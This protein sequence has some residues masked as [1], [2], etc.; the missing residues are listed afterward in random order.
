MFAVAQNLAILFC[1]GMAFSVHL[2]PVPPQIH[3]Y[4]MYKV[5]IHRNGEIQRKY[6]LIDKSTILGGDVEVHRY[7]SVLMSRVVT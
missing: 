2:E 3:K 5:H 6:M 7:M 4:G 1:L